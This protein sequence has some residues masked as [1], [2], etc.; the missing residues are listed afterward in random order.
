MK[1]IANYRGP[2]KGANEQGTMSNAFASCISQFLD[3]RSVSDA[4]DSISHDFNGLEKNYGRAHDDIFYADPPFLYLGEFAK[5]Y[6]R[7]FGAFGR[8]KFAHS[9][10]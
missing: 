9:N 2:L 10:G 1:S 5:R 4:I 8:V 7:D 3:A 6:D